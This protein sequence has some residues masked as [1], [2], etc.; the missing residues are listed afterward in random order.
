VEGTEGKW[1]GPRAVKGKE[2]LEGTENH[3]VEQRAIKVT[4]GHGEDRGSL[5]W[6]RPY[7]GH[8]AIEGTEDRRGATKGRRGDIGP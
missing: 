4:E 7:S 2:G 6:Q 8:R 3:I 5:R 1:K